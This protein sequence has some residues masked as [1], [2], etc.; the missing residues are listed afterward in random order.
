MSRSE[1]ELQISR[2]LPVPLG[3]GGI[4]TIRFAA[5]L[6]SELKQM[7][8]QSHLLAANLVNQL[9]NLTDRVQFLTGLPNAQSK[10]TVNQIRELVLTLVNELSSLK[11][12]GK[13]LA[14]QVS[15]QLPQTI[16]QIAANISS[17]L[18]ILVGQVQSLGGQVQAQLGN[19]LRYFL[20]QIRRLQQTLRDDG[21]ILVDDLQFKLKGD[22]M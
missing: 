5:S 10:Q 9:Q 2:Q 4:D 19:Q 8:N 21:E 1:L 12:Q 16:H 20:D 17:Q 15:T 11:N 13:S 14:G 3:N 18:N 7:I 22:G 6:G